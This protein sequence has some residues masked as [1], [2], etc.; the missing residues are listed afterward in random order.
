[1]LQSMTDVLIYLV[2][3]IGYMYFPPRSRMQEMALIV[4]LT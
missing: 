4:T 1:M 2:T 3:K